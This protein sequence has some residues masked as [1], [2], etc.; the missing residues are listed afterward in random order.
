VTSADILSEIHL[1]IWKEFPKFEVL[2]DVPYPQKK[3]SS[4]NPKWLHGIQELKIED[5]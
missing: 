2:T 1:N 5:K 3:S 4:E